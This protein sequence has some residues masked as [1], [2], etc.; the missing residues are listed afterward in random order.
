M[1][2]FG[3]FKNIFNNNSSQ[4]SVTHKIIVTNVSEESDKQQITDFLRKNTEIVPCTYSTDELTKQGFQKITNTVSPIFSQLPGI[5]GT[6]L[7]A[8][9]YRIRLPEG[10][11]VNDLMKLNRNN[12]MTTILKKGGKGAIQ[13]SASLV[14]NA[15]AAVLMGVFT[16]LSVATSQYFL[17]EINNNIVNIKNRL[18]NIDFF[19]KAEKQSELLASID[20]MQEIQRDYEQISLNDNYQQAVLTNIIDVKK[21]ANADIKFYSNMVKRHFMQLDAKKGKKE[22]I[23]ENLNM[24]YESIENLKYSTMLYMYSSIMQII[25]S[26][27]MGNAEYIE[28]IKSDMADNRRIFEDVLAESLE[29]YN[30][31]I[32]LMKSRIFLGG[33]IKKGKF[34]PDEFFNP[35]LIEDDKSVFCLKFINTMDQ[36]KLLNSN[37]ARY[38]VCDNDLYVYVGE[39]E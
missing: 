21:K 15:P 3:F 20:F 27:N 2:F 5:I 7:S 38:V 10:F 13:G 12:E 28:A 29:N 17:K 34:N 22:D 4:S 25:Y 9:S 37:N 19:L 14:S 6:T 35:Q 8:S 18:N 24:I 26:D 32:D 31:N 36:I 30:V 1:G 11:T 23:S 39:N 16:V 33:D